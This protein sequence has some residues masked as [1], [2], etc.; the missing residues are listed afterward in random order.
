MRT[1]FTEPAVAFASLVEL[2][3]WR[4]LRQPEQRTHTYLVDGEVEGDHLTH[5]ALDREARSI[6]AL[7][8]NNHAVG[9]RALL[10]YPAGLEFIAA[11]F[12]CLYAGVIA[13]PQPAPNLAQALRTLPRLL[14][15]IRDAQPSV[16]LTTSAIFANT[17][18]L[19][20]Q[21]PE[22]R[23]LR[24]V[25]TDEVA[26]SL[27][28]EWRDPAVT[29]N[30]V[31]LLQY[32]SG[33][34]AEPKGVMISHANLLH[35]SAYIS[36]LFAFNPNGV[37]VTWLPA[38]HDMGLTNGIIQPVYH[39]RPCYLMPAVAFLMQPIRWLRAIS[40]YKATI[41]GGPNFAYDLCTRR[42]TPEQRE[43]LD[44]GS[45]DVAYNGAE[46]VRADTMQRFAATFAACGFRRG[47]LHPCCGLAEATLLVSG[48]SLRQDMF[49]TIQAAEFEQNRVL[50]VR[51][52]NEAD[53]GG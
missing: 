21:A 36:R 47:A 42:I 11:F 6:G 40:R 14:A 18:E 50:E 46:P 23:K 24:W 12:G 31:A 13:V 44:L 35:N 48:G 49:R 7:L 33:S 5:A 29:R 52:Q 53:A 30:T 15:I 26:G 41:S 37:T 3:R 9:E 8:Q 27:A 20:R 19:F 28:Q 10:L 25:A 22:L 16:V 1:D 51:A 32:T 4:A 2:L 43:T 34:T 38:F 45:W 17:E 39:G